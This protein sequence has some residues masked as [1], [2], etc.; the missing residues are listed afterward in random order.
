MKSGSGDDPFADDE[1]DDQGDVDDDL[2]AEQ[3]GAAGDDP[4]ATPP[5]ATAEE[6]PTSSPS[7]TSTPDALPAVPDHPADE[8]SALP[9]I[10]RRDGVKDGRSHKTIHYTEHTLKR[11]RRELLGAVEDELGEDIEL[12]DAREAAYLV[13]MDHV[14][15]IAEVLREWGYAIE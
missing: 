2:D 8:E 14:D 13:G 12:T 3:H 1:S 5:S 15:E 11:E 4:F 10:H 7:E 6:T 9:W